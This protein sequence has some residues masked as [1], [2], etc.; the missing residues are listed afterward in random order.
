MCILTEDHTAVQ[1]GTSVLMS[2]GNIWRE[3]P[4]KNQRIKY[5]VI[6]NKVKRV[7]FEMVTL[8]YISDRKKIYYDIKNEERWFCRYTFFKM[9]IFFQS[10]F[11]NSKVLLILKKDYQLKMYM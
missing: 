5:M 1:S 9:Y 4:I 7:N 10:L 8:K 2:L 11:R 3:N 6:E